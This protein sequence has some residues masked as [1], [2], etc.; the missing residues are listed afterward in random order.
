[1][2][3]YF[4]TA[5]LLSVAQAA[6]PEVPPAAPATAPFTVLTDDFARFADEMVN[7]PDAERVAKF[8]AVFDPLLPGFYNNKG[9]AQARFDSLIAASLKSFP[10]D[11]AASMATTERFA[12][13]YARGEVRFRTFFRDYRQQMPVYL[14]Q[15]I[16]QMD[17]GTRTIN[18]RA[19]LVFGAEMI[20]HLHDQ[21]TIGPL[22]DHELFHTYHARF[23][24]GCAQLW[25]SLWREGLATYVAERMNPGA[26]DRQLLLTLPAAIRPLV[27]PRL[28]AAMCQLREQV[29]FNR[30]GRLCGIFQFS[31]RQKCLSV[32]LW[33]LSG[34]ADC[35]EDRERCAA[36][37]AGPNARHQGSPDDRGCG[38][39]L[40]RMSA[41]GTGGGIGG[42][43]NALRRKQQLHRQTR[44]I[45]ASKPSA[46][47][48]ASAIG[49]AARTPPALRASVMVSALFNNRLPATGSAS[50]APASAA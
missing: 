22:L 16:N 30:A 29:R 18:G 11:R 1:M 7:I 43:G 20:T 14:V 15:S 36:G 41:R 48:A 8:H 37:K 35:R 23:F 49:T 27:D 24:R 44:F 32:T 5:A 26:T 13:A 33:L 38:G 12:D 45:T 2:P 39:K 28:G 42:T 3:V 50:A 21:S 4:L 17:G 31:C 25:C 10:G 34:P 46:A 19:T 6:P 9:A 40:W 47:T